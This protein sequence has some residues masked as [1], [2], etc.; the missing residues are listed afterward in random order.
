MWDEEQ[1]IVK[2]KGMND[3]FSFTEKDGQ[4]CRSKL[5]GTCNMSKL[6]SFA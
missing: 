5:N 2:I 4:L 6:G 3:F 1:K